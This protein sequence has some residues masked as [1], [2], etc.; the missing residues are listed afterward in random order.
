M[1]QMKLLK[2]FKLGLLACV[3]LFS[4]SILAQDEASNADKSDILVVTTVHSNLDKT[5]GSQDEWLALEK[6]YFDKVTS[7]NEYILHTN[8]LIHYFTASSTERKVIT[9]YSTWDDMQKANKRTGELIEEGWPDSVARNIF[10]TDRNSYYS[11][12]HSDEIYSTIS[13]GKDLAE[14]PT[15]SMIYYVRVMQLAYPDDAKPGELKAL[16]SE[17]IDN[18]MMKNDYV[19][20]FY[21]SRHM[22]GNDSRDFVEVTV[23][24]SLNDMEA[25]FDKNDELIKAYYTGDEGKA[26]GEKAGK[27]FTGFHADYIYS[28]VPELMK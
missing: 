24:S 26:K 19:K 15:E 8:F 18:V 4:Q 23:L 11:P 10:F 12:Y 7:K 6:E 27:Y 20:A 17:F 5:D 9:V 22:W 2:H 14:K 3:F 16:R 21:Q 13:G 28:N 1:K 25:Y